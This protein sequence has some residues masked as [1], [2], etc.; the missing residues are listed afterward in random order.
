MHNNRPKNTPRQN[1]TTDPH[2][3][4]VKPTHQVHNHPIWNQHH[5]PT[6]TPHETNTS[7]PQTHHV[8]HIRSTNTPRQSN[9]LAPHTPRQ[10]AQD[11]RTHQ[12]NR[13]KCLTPAILSLTPGSTVPPQLQ[14]KVIKGGTQPIREQTN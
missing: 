9:T 1:N 6:N 10:P 4:Y 12:V 3:D 7:G 2:T 14:T 8:K 11:P 5:R 13:A